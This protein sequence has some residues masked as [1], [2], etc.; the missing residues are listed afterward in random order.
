MSANAFPINPELTSIAMAYRNPAVAL[1]ADKVLPRVPVAKQ[2]KYTVYSAEQGYTLPDTKVGRKSQP[3]EVEFFGTLVQGE[4]LDWGLD[5]IVPID[6]IQAWE[7]MLKPAS[8][9]PMNPL[10]ISTMFLEGLIQ[11]DR[12]V[13][14]A[15]LVF[16]SAT[17]PAANVTTLSGTSKWSDF[18]NSNPLL[19]IMTALDKP[20]QRPRQVV[21][22][23]QVWTTIRQNPK[24][25]Q[26]VY[27]TA[28]T[29]GVVDKKALADKLEVEE[30]I[31]GAGWVNTARKGQAPNYQRVWGN[32]TALLYNDPMAA[33]A[34]QPTFGFTGQ[35][36]NKVAGTLPEPK[37]G[38]SGSERVRV[39]EKVIE[40]VAAGA[41][42]ALFQNCV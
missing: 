38:L 23:Q 25:V 7:K 21:F 13:R 39:G 22:G 2:F 27:G 6:D 16:N 3:N 10:A 41:L 20:L 12:E 19:D 17:Y 24:F 15:N 18:V 8:G 40:V 36:G 32:S 1:I 34:L 29:Y 35:F 31:V 37:M 26:A 4:T 33:Q 5:D 14:V 28:Q 9:G 42:G 30:V 11:L